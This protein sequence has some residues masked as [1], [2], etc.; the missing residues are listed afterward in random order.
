MEKFWKARLAQISTGH[1]I[2]LLALAS[3]DGKQDTDVAGIVELGMSEAETGPFRG[4]LEML[5]VSPKYR[6][7]GLASKLL[8]ALEDVAKEEKRTLLVSL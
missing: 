1:R 4:D 7:R 3:S 5:M 6:R 2:T 8:E